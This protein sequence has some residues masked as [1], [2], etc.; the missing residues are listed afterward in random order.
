M[1]RQPIISVLGHVDS[2]KTTILD[3]IRRST[4]AAREAGG[5]TQHIGATEVP[6]DVV[7]RICGQMLDSM[8]VKITIPGLLFI[9]TPGHEAF[10]NLRK[11]GGSIADLAVLV[12][13]IR[14]GFMPQTI[15]ALEI[16]KTYKTPF[17]IA[18]NKIDSLP[19][20]LNTKSYSFTQAFK[21]QQDFVKKDLENRVYALVGRLS[22]FRIDGDRFDRVTDFTKQVSMVPVS[23]KTGEGIA[24]VLMVLSGLSQRYLEKSLQIEV[25]GPGRG[26]ILE[27]K[28]ERG[29]GTSLDVILYDG[30]IKRGD[31]VVLSGKNGPIETK[32]KALLRPKPL[33]E[34]RDP[35]D[36]FSNVH[37]VSAASG[38]KLIGPGIEEAL[39]GGQVYVA[40]GNTEALKQV[41]S[42]EL[43][44]LRFEKEQDGLILRAD[45]LGSL[46]ALLKMFGNLKIPVRKADIGAIVRKDII[47]A[48]SL[49]RRNPE[50]GIV[51]AFNAPVPSDIQQF[52]KDSG[53]MIL[54]SKI[55]Y[56]IIEG[57]EE[58]RKGVKQQQE[59]SVFDALPYPSELIFLDGCTFRRSGPAIVGVEVIRGRVQPGYQ[60]MKRDGTRVGVIESIQD[61]GKKLAD[62]KKGA[63]VAVAIE[64]PLV[65][66]HINEGDTFYTNITP[67]QYEGLIKSG[68]KFFTPEDE[69]LLRE[70]MQIVRKRGSS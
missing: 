38:L 60:L 4:V 26:S 70:I 11:R 65:G 58:W 43:E 53:V 28:E 56:R 21:Q 25:K 24:E 6:I 1:I 37:S 42:K 32:V 50:Y 40:E 57:Y 41:I 7:R 54:E 67:R 51:I 9:D 68:R 8:R 34:M 22:E 12:I 46:E 23:A 45:T 3:K 61:K 33:D 29:L 69:E 48:E 10:T 20:W 62:A 18:A 17:I 5:I 13:D 44:A 49:K 35:K 63:K 2:G 52:A 15:E 16:L 31:I 59:T 64:G 27:V 14:E 66:R 36:K 30:T 55:I 19:S 39:P 47:E